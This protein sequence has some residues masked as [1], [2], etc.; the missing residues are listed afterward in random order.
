MAL[1]HEFENCSA[2]WQLAHNHQRTPK[3]I[4]SLFSLAFSFFSILAA[5]PL[6]I[7]DPKG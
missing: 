1:G 4:F 7:G 5:E 3:K 6:D 2:S